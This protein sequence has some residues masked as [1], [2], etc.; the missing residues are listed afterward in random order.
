MHHRHGGV[1]P[2]RPISNVS[3]HLHDVL[4]GHGPLLIY[5]AVIRLGLYTADDPTPSQ[6]AADMD[7]NLF[8]NILNSLHH[9]VLHKLFPAKTK[10]IY[11]LRPRPHPLSL[12]VKIDCNNFINRLLLKDIYYLFTNSHGCVLSTMF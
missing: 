12:T 7:D 3:K 6:L 8:A 1:L 5:R 2:A 11:S 4:F 9:H 10:H